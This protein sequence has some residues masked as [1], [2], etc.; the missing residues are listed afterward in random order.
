M[1]NGDFT[2]PFLSLLPLFFACA[3]P[4][5]TLMFY[6]FPRSGLLNITHHK[7]QYNLKIKTLHNKKNFEGK[8]Y[9]KKIYI[10]RKVWALFFMFLITLSNVSRMDGA[11]D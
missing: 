10:D 9:E 5:R 11:L 8:N 3:L 2:L 7:L 1:M 6:K 4:Y